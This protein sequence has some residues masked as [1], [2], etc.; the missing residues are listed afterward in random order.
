VPLASSPQARLVGIVEPAGRR[1]PAARAMVD[2][3]RA[4]AKSVDPLH[5]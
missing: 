5:A 3:I 4:A 1:T 2:E